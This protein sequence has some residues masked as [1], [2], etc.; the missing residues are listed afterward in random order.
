MCS[1]GKPRKLASDRYSTDTSRSNRYQCYGTRYRSK[2]VI[3]KARSSSTILLLVAPLDLR[4]L[5]ESPPQARRP[6]AGELREVAVTVREAP[7]ERDAAAVLL[8]GEE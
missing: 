5:S 2:A 7:L 4:H 8:V 3:N 1:R 6:D